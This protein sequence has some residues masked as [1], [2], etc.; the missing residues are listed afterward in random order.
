MP[1]LPGYERI[2]VRQ[3]N[4]R[5]GGIPAAVEWLLKYHEVAL[6]TDWSDFQE[7]VDLA[8]PITNPN[9]FLTIPPKIEEEY[10][11]SRKHLVCEDIMASEWKCQRIR[12]LLDAGRA[13]L[14]ALRNDENRGYHIMP[15]V[16]YDA[17][18]L[19][20]LDLTRPVGQQQRQYTWDEVKTRHREH[21][22]GHDLLWLRDTP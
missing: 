17:V 18:C 13:C 9:S 21:P 1:S 19:T 6:P 14:I 5:S 4:L 10:G 16:A 20:V 11:F 22:G 15:V 7:R 8:T 12:D 3:R 2:A